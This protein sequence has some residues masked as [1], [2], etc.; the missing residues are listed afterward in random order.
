MVPRILAEG[1]DLLGGLIQFFECLYAAKHDACFLVPCI[2]LQRRSR[3]GVL[4]NCAAWK[5]ESPMSYGKFLE[6]AGCVAVSSAIG[7]TDAAAMTF[8]TF[9]RFMPT[10]GEAL[11]FSE[12]AMQSLSNWSERA[13]GAGPAETTRLRASHPSSRIYAGGKYVTSAKTAI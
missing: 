13:A 8:N 10:A 5:F 6:L 4:S 9:R 3:K 2:I 7:Q 11:Q 1:V 12:T